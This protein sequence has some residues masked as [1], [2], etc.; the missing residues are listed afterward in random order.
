MFFIIDFNL[1]TSKYIIVPFSSFLFKTYK[2]ISS[3]DK[4]LSGVVNPMGLRELP[5][6]RGAPVGMVPQIRCLAFT[7]LSESPLQQS[8]TV[9]ASFDPPLPTTSP[10]PPF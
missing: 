6:R 3:G 9:M 4:T 2:S 8:T 1:N 5:P 7:F 10:F